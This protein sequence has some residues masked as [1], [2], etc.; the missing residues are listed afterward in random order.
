MSSAGSLPEATVS[1]SAFT[2]HV[3]SATSFAL[4]KSNQFFTLIV[5]AARSTGEACR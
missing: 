3:P 2:S 1:P 5:P 4:V